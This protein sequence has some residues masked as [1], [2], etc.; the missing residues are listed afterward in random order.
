VKLGHTTRAE[1]IRAI[2]AVYAL[3]ATAT[4]TACS[5]ASELVPGGISDGADDGGADATITPPNDGATRS[6]DGGIVPVSDSGSMPEP[7]AGVPPVPDSGAALG[8][9]W[10]LTG[11]GDGKIRSFAVDETSGA[12]TEKSVTVAVG[13][14]TF[15]A[16]DVKRGRVF[17]VDE[18]G[19]KLRAFAFNQATGVL[20]QVGTA[21]ASQGSGPT[22]VS[23]DPSGKWAFVANYNGGTTAVFPIGTDGSLGSFVAKQSPGQNAH[24]A[25][26]NPSGTHLFVPCLGSNF[27]AQYTLNSTTGALSANSPPSV[28]IPSNAGNP[29]PRHMAFLPNEKFAYVLNEVNSTL[30]T[31]S[32]DAATGRLTL[33]GS[34]TTLPA[35][36]FSNTT[37]EVFVHPNGQF[38]Y[39]SNRGHNSIATFSISAAGTAVLL[40]HQPTGGQTPRSFALDPAGRLLFAAN[41]NSATVTAFTIEPSGKP[42]PATVPST[43]VPA[44]AFVGAWRLP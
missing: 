27:V 37:A 15:L 18:G 43:P 34:T 10:V 19:E 21:V 7:D 23:I 40:G 1:R 16:M 11:S 20:T 9:L 3:L 22:H 25:I 6:S 42:K 4:A 5:G 33:V 36:A 31:L 30:S 12:L 41:Q 2:L 14:P 38:L 29:G 44:P 39:A 13:S 24:Q 26:T 8:T 35:G 17:A 32:F 28:A